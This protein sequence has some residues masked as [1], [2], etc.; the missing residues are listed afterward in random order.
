MSR[1]GWPQNSKRSAS[2][3]F[4]SRVEQFATYITYTTYAEPLLRAKAPTD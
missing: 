4:E 1:P 2:Q 3:S